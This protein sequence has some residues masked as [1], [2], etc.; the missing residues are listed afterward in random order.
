MWRLLGRRGLSFSR[1]LADEAT[2]PS[3]PVKLLNILE[4]SRTGS[5][6]L[7]QLSR[8]QII[9]SC[10]LMARDLRFIDDYSSVFKP[11]ILV[12]SNALIVGAEHVRAIILKD[13]VLLFGHQGMWGRQLGRLLEATINGR[14]EL[15][16]D[17][18]SSPVSIG[19]DVAH[20]HAPFFSIP[21]DPLPPHADRLERLRTARAAEEDVRVQHDLFDGGQI[22]DPSQR[23]IQYLE[24]VH[25]SD[26]VDANSSF[27]F[28]ALECI[29]ISITVAL[30]V[31]LYRLSAAVEAVLGQLTVKVSPLP[32]RR[33]LMLKTGL[34][35]FEV[36]LREVKNTLRTILEDDDTMDAMYLTV[37]RTKEDDHDQAEMLLETYALT[38]DQMANE[39]SRLLSTIR[40]SEE[41]MSITQDSAR[42]RIITLNLFASSGAFAMSTG[43]MVTGLFGMNFD[44]PNWVMGTRLFGL[45]PFSSI[46]AVSLVSLIACASLCYRYYG[47]TSVR[48][49]LRERTAINA[50]VPY[51]ED[52]EEALFRLGYAGRPL[53]MFQFRVLLETVLRQRVP[54]NDL[55]YLFASQD[56]DGK[57]YI[58]ANRFLTELKIQKATFRHVGASPAQMAARSSDSR[59]L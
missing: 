12:R 16:I 48:V 34:N 8:S 41:V 57:G 59:V 53:D 9:S 50:F 23:S 17:A 6:Q 29:L 25:N 31:H 35:A 52:V 58:D 28:R 27:E 38:M 1:V 32:L 13:K 47:G 43:T 24:R 40:A 45:D 22:E 21:T 15:L 26:V 51:A 19:R 10:S 5:S 37:P 3:M 2:R 44:F 7:L 11:K 42:N 20:A 39:T 46:A 33:L 4:I 55:K 14:T 54:E 56:E 49:N 30:D 36:Q 18:P